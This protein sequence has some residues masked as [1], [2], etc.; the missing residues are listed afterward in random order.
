MHS[1]YFLIGMKNKVTLS[2]RQKKIYFC[3][4][5]W[6]GR[7]NQLNQEEK[8]EKELALSFIEFTSP[9]T[10]TFTMVSLDPLFPSS[11]AYK[12]QKK[13]DFMHVSFK[14]VSFN[15]LLMVVSPYY[16]G[17][18]L[19]CRSLF[20]FII[21]LSVTLLYRHTFLNNLCCFLT[22]LFP[23]SLHTNYKISSQCY[24]WRG[25]TS[26]VHLLCFSKAEI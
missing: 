26:T 4:A 22:K 16:N 21:T 7:V 25:F 5:L 9:C 3:G 1:N 18:H 10:Y 24:F 15:I 19:Q 13:I 23:S 20:K 14:H 6:A 17:K 12:R 2:K 8:N 11:K